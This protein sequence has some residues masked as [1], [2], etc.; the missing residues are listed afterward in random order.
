[1]T[2]EQIRAF[3]T[4]PLH[5]MAVYAIVLITIMVVMALVGAGAGEPSPDPAPGYSVTEYGV[6]NLTR[7]LVV[8]TTP[9]PVTQDAFLVV[10]AI[11]G[12][13]AVYR[14][15][16]DEAE[17]WTFYSVVRMLYGVAAQNTQ[18]GNEQ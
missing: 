9:I 14:Y 1:M 3:F 6:F 17:A 5:A 11:D 16:D 2:R 4:D 15:F 7:D 13:G 8:L 18:G 12:T 10:Y